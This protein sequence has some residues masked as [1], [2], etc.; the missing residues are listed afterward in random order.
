[1]FA[2]FKDKIWEVVSYALL[3]ILIVLPMVWFSSL[4]D[5]HFKAILISLLVL[6]SFDLNGKAMKGV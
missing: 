5:S 1:M 4:S 2:M 3:K 6:I